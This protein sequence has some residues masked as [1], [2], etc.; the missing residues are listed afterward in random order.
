MA[1]V[2]TRSLSRYLAHALLFTPVLAAWG[3]GLGGRLSSA[4]MALFAF[5]VRLVT[6]AKAHAMERA[7]RRGPAEVVLRRLMYGPLT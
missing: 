7:G 6:V 3:L 1:S 4:A 2:G 5:A